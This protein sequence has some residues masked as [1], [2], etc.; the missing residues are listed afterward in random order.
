MELKDIRE[1]ITAIDDQL[2]PLFLDRMELARQ[3]AESKRISGKPIYD[4]AR[5]RQILSDVTKRSGDMDEYA[6]LFFSNLMEISRSYQ[7]QLLSGTE[8]AV[9]PPPAGE[10]FPHAASVACQGL[11]GA[12]SQAAADKA[13][14]FAD[15]LFFKTFDGVFQA[16]E[17][18]M[19]RFGVLPIEN[20]A[21]GSVA[22]VYDLMQT[23]QFSIVRAVKLHIDHHL[24][25]P[26]GTR[27]EDIR[28]V[29][30]HE[31]AIGQCSA[32][33]DG[34]KDVEIRFCE[35]TAIAAQTVA[36]SKE[37][38]LAAISS[39]ACA[40][41]YNLVNLKSHI[42]NT[43]N[44]YTR[45]IIIEKTPKVY[46]G[47]NK[48]SLM[49]SLPNTPGSLGKIMSRFSCSSLNLSKLESRPV[50]GT[51]FHYVFYADLEASV[52]EPAVRRLM[53]SLAHELPLFVFLGAYQEV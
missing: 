13:F 21:H 10:A 8:D 24:L 26:K 14:R 38:G 27:L 50:E 3:V 20:S 48:I 2:L 30:S 15:I 39:S 23:H 1:R 5:E 52:E 34:L 11:E 45:F 49:F 42:Q 32:F 43:D 28:A 41:Q 6:R 7:T 16:V 9:L 31:Q 37:P 47:S 12:Y 40:A 46:P 22:K 51:D 25:A 36:E 33:L 19:C 35:N 44:N 18:G 29:I 17:K 53:S 4:A